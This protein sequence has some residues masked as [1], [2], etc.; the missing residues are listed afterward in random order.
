[1]AKTQN[2]SR[3]NTD[4]VQPSITIPAVQELQKPPATL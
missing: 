3:R 2:T 4:A 1:M